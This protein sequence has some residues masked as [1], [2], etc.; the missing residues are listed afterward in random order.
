MKWVRQWSLTVKLV[1]SLVLVLTLLFGAWITINLGQVKNLSMHNGE[2]EAEIAGEQFATQIKD[3][4][5]ANENMLKALSI[6]LM[7]AREHQT[8][9]REQVV[10]L[11]EKMLA[12]DEKVLAIYTLWEPNQFD[13]ADAR[14]KNINAY[15]DATGRFIPYVVRSDNQIIVDP[16]VDY[17]QQGAG[18][19]YLLPK[20]TNKTTLVE[21][22]NY[23]VGNKTVLI[24]SLV[25]PMLDES[26]AFVGIVGVDFSLDSLQTEAL[27]YSPMGGHV[28]II[29][30]SGVYIA[31]SNSADQVSQTYLDGPEKQQLWENVVQGARNSGYTSNAKGDEEL[32]VLLPVKLQAANEAWYVE[33]VI[34]QYSILEQYTSERLKSIIIALSSL[35]ITAFIVYLCIRFMVTRRLGAFNEKFR[36]MS[37]GD[38][39]QTIKIRAADELGEMGERFNA[40]SGELRSMFRQVSDLSLSVGATSEQLT[41]GAEQTG[42]AAETITQS[43]QEVAGGSEQQQQAS[44]QMMRAIQEMSVGIQKIAEASSY[45]A[46][47]VQEVQTQTVQGNTQIH[48]SVAQI[49]QAQERVVQSEEALRS[50]EQK[51]QEITGIIDLITVISNQTNMLALNAGIEAARAGE[52]GKGFAVVANEVRR[53]AE[54][55]K[56]AAN[57]IRAVMVEIQSETAQAVTAVGMSTAEVKEGTQ[58]VQE[59]GR[60]FALITEEMA[61]ATEQVQEV[62]AAAE[63]MTASAESVMQTT[64]HLVHIAKD[65][66]DNSQQ[67]AAASEQQL[68]SMQEIT[69]AAESLSSMVQELMTSVTRFKI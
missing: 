1:T 53:L 26:G 57:Q 63:Q 31:N 40:M 64:E 12:A 5:V 10:A 35:L 29:S 6:L 54:Q 68:A 48:Q 25:L 61:K 38:F 47:A 44:G 45:V 17:E 62:S 69:S 8:Y 30:N 42:Q 16:L 60:I 20:Q 19:Y 21:P 27:A 13:G 33:S 28:N 65:A 41:A 46:G 22:Y 43:I 24:T 4:L 51:S 50:L 56:D 36:L 3:K 34:P 67:V 52:Q 58:S 18:D 66:A 2:L 23:Q 59:S 49:L 55:T 7:D 32:R 14:Y 15:H 39:T 11:F 37:E 9:S